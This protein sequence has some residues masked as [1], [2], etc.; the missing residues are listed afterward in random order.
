MKYISDANLK[1]L[2]QVEVDMLKE[3]DEFC[4]K[5]DITYFL[6]YG[7]LLGSI[8]HKG[9]IPWDDDLDIGMF[10]EDYEKFIKIFPQTNKSP[11]YV[12]CMENDPNYWLSFAKIRKSN[13][14]M[15]EE[16]NKDLNINSEI[17]IDVF[18][19]DKA[20]DGG[21]KKI[22]IRANIIRII[23]STIHVKRKTG[24]LKNCQHK[25][26]VTLFRIL[27]VK[28]LYKI[29]KKLLM[30]DY[31]KDTSHRVC[32]FTVYPVRTEYMNENIFLPVSR[33]EFEKEKFNII[34]KPE[35]FLKNI[36]GDY[37]KLPPVS[38]RVNHSIIK[39][40]FNK[41]E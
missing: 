15:L 25:A 5:N 8:R 10:R 38:K 13:T 21:Y 17:F 3:I 9:F 16:N 22:I 33:G 41:G 28:L 26:F 29:E 7:S 6:I 19:F 32:Y 18:P 20:K 1:K 14:L 12:Q 24:K 37:M 4:K 40:D 11:M 2:H 36:Y 35:E 39:V 27:P 30:K 31:K 23:T 34:N